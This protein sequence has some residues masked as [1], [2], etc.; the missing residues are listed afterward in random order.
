[1]TSPVDCMPGPTDGSTP[2]SLAVENAG[3]L[4]ATNGGGGRSPSSQPSS[5]SVAPSE[6]RTASST[7]GTP[8]TLDMNGTVR[9]AR[10]LTSMRY[11]P[12]SRTMNWALTRPLRAE[13][14]HD[15]VH[16]GHDQVLVALAH[17]LRREDADAV[18]AVDAGPL[19]VLEEPR[20]EHAIAVADGVDVDLDALEVA[21]DA[22]RPVRVDDRG[23]RQLAGQVLRR[24]A[25]VDGQAADDERRPDDDRVA[26]PLGEGQR[27]LDA[28]GHAA[29][30]LR[31]AEPVEQGREADALLGLVD[32]L[33]V[34]A[35]ERDAAGGQRRGQVERRLAAERDDGRA[36]GRRPAASR[37]R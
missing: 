4:T 16:R 21:V 36:G 23:R 13:G 7:I 8:V 10:G 22:D 3:A 34:A 35:E 9:E 26:D 25:E 6:I 2:R 37:H 28:V 15:P 19:D 18:A 1:M 27:L 31:D 20:D 30:R 14:Q 11:T 17:G 12:S 24:V 32:G 29:L 5:S 33:E